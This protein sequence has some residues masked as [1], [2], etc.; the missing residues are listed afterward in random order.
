MC[1]AVEPSQ[2][3]WWKT[4]IGLADSVERYEAILRLTL[5][6]GGK[7]SKGQQQVLEIFTRDVC[8]LHLPISTAIWTLYAQNIP[9][10]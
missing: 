1:Q 2:Q 6:D 10:N 8:A 5:G 9:T 3:F 7:L 4:A